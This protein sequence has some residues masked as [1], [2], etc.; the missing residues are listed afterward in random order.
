MEGK[1]EYFDRTS[2]VSSLW[3]QTVLYY[4]MLF[5]L[6]VFPFL[7]AITWYKV[8]AL[9][10]RPALSRPA[11]ASHHPAPSPSARAQT[12]YIQHVVDKQ[13]FQSLVWPLLV[14]A[15]VT[16]VFRVYYGYSGNLTEQVSHMSS[17][18]LLTVFPQ[19]PALAFLCLLQEHPYPFERTCGYLM[20]VM[21]VIEFYL[22]N[23]ANQKLIRRQTA[24]F[25]RLCQDT[26]E[27]TAAAL[28]KRD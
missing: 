20:L 25:L 24:S 23:Q 9:C 26:A 27:A 6:M 21:L 13:F 1:A 19:I 7:I 14:I 16:E 4:N 17:F 22:G 11:P 10:R 12:T 2:L 15:T 5:S 18:L 3:L 8:G 28:P